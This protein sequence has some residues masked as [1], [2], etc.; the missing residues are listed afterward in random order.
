[1]SIFR[2]YDVR[3]IADK[4]LT[5]EIAWGLG[6][7]LGLRAK[8]AGDSKV[9][10][11]RDVRVSS[12]RLANALASGFEAADVAV[13]QLQPGPT[14]LL[15]FAAYKNIPEFETRS[16]IMV[17]GSHNP[18]EYNGFKIVIGG[19]TLFGADIQS[20]REDVLSFAKQAPAKI[21]HTAKQMDRIPD[22]VNY[23]RENI[24]LKR[25]LKVV[26]DAG[27]G[28]A[29]ELGIKTYQALGCDVIPLFCEPDGTF[30][31]HHPDPTV[32][33]NLA[34]LIEKVRSSGAELGI[35]FD[36]DGDR[37]GAVTATGRILYGDHLVLY[38]ARDI[39]KDVPGAT[40]ISEVKSSQVLYD[41]LEK[42]GAKP[43]LWKTGHSLIKAK[44]KETK[45]QMAGEMSGHMFFAHRFFG[46]DD[47][48]YAGARLIEGLSQHNETLDQFLDSLPPMTN[49]PELRIDCDDSKK[50]Q[51]VKDFTGA[52]K[53]KFG[54]AVND[55]DGAR[56]KMH[57][58]WG[59][60]RASNTQPVLVMRFEAGDRSHLKSIRDEFAQI[61][62]EIKANVVVPE[63]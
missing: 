38:F 2:E 14:P 57:G 49:T 51:V 26:I 8:K 31:N 52:A 59:L 58:G 62:N 21:T 20:I 47:A 50:F 46:F 18:P 3:G 61:M 6:K 35:A 44:L 54:S 33:K 56:I 39:L 11:G 45:A 10:I 17:T 63:V 40:I 55:I 29:G 9:Y 48:I 28:A 15:Y 53:K 19:Q 34:H 60:V 36:G 4:D 27:N 32:P 5:N 22:Y 16:G 13:T 43:I 37:I 25:R 30:P 23:V 42:W 12:P 41:Q 7:A 1:M 24:S